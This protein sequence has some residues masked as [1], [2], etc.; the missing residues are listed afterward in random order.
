VS[1]HETACLPRGCRVNI[2][3]SALDRAKR[4]SRCDHLDSFDHMQDFVRCFFI[5][6][7]KLIVKSILGLAEKA[8]YAILYYIDDM[9]FFDSCISEVL[10][11]FFKKYSIEYEMNP[12]VF[13]QQEDSP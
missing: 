10:Y 13:I 12:W 11:D 7:M 2:R 1:P 9:Q 8:C 6:H 5:D 4:F 3:F